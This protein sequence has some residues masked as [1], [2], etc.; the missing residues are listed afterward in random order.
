MTYSLQ[1]QQNNAI[2]NA[3]Q[4]VIDALDA[5]ETK[6]QQRNYKQENIELIDEQEKLK[7]T[8]N[9]L[10]EQYSDLQTVAATIYEKLDNSIERLAQILERP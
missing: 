3:T 5:L 9:S 4:R 2:Y 8:I 7:A 6:L 1:N 10:T